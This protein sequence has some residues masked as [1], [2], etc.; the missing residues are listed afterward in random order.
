[1]RRLCIIDNG[2]SCKLRKVFH[3]LIYRTVYGEFYIAFSRRRRLKELSDFQTNT[4]INPNL[5]FFGRQYTYQLLVGCDLYEQLL[6]AF[7]GEDKALLFRK[8]LANI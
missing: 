2:K 1:M 3:V 4:P 7:G 5:L 6:A 8:H